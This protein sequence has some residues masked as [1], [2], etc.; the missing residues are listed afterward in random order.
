MELFSGLLLTLVVLGI[1][2]LVGREFVSA[3]DGEGL[4][5][6]LGDA[7]DTAAPMLGKLGTVVDSPG[8][9]MWVR[10]D[11]ERWRANPVGDAS[12]APGTPIH[13]TG[14]KGLVVDV[15]QVSNGAAAVT[16]ASSVDPAPIRGS[17][18]AD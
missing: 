16:E 10:V 17:G 18:Q 11:G 13:V 9:F 5:K 6:Y 4:R 1:I 12:L 15:E 7:S 14:L 8:E 3:G 2:A